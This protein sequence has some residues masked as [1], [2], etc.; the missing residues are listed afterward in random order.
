MKYPPF[1]DFLALSKSL[2]RTS[3][4]KKLKGLLLQ[5]WRAEACLG[6]LLQASDCCKILRAKVDEKGETFGPEEQTTVKALQTTAVNL[7]VRATSTS[8]K[9]GERGSIQLNNSELTKGQKE[10]HRDLINLRNN[11]LAHVNPEHKMRD[12]VWHKVILFAVPN[13]IG[14]LT[15]AAATNETTWNRA[16]LECL[17]RMLPLAITFMEANFVAKLKAAQEALG[18]AELSEKT[19]QKFLFDPVDVFGSDAIVQRILESRGKASDR[20]WVEE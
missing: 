10:D 9:L 18:D 3:E 14:Q 17:E 16:T 7:Y 19:F 13:R 20:F 11:A 5:V 6:D 4:Q 12:R 1:V 8:G 15:P 2:N